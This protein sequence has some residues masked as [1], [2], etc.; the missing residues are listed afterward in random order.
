MRCTLII[1][2]ASY[3]A[4]RLAWCATGCMH[5]L[6]YLL[7]TVT[8]Y[9]ISPHHGVSQPSTLK[10]VALRVHTIEQLRGRTASLS[11]QIRSIKYACCMSFVYRLREL[12]CNICYLS[13]L[14]ASG[15]EPATEMLAS[16]FEHLPSSQAVSEPW[17][18][19][20]RATM[21]GGSAI[22]DTDAAPR[23]VHVT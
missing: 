9:T 15:P 7:Y 12:Q 4:W 18:G 13:N 23:P 3:A 6:L 22:S 11:Y 14:L 20:A 8:M 1:Q 10:R 21:L 17:K 16:C 5:V 2:S 19:S